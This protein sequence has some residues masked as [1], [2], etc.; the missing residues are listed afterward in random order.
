MKRGN[1][2]PVFIFLCHIPGKA[3]HACLF[4]SHMLPSF[5]RIISA[6]QGEFKDIMSDYG[7]LVRLILACTYLWHP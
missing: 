1:S 4:L 3:S 5:C 2:V 7:V 6:K